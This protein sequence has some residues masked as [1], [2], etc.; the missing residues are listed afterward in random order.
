M[1]NLED[2][3]FQTIQN[4]R[5]LRLSKNAN[6]SLDEE[7]EIETVLKDLVR[8]Y[9]DAEGLVT[10]FDDDLSYAL[11]MALSN[12]E[13]DK[14][15]GLTFSQD[16]FQSSI[17]KQVPKGHVFRAFPIQF[18]HKNPKSMFE[19]MRR[20]PNCEEIIKANGAEIHFCLRTKIVNYAEDIFA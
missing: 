10:R 3:G 6:M 15:F 5:A 2:F 13:T 20:N 8:V 9:R 4:I 11:T 16:E 7:E 18:T 19:T 17:K 12:Y 1:G 14:L